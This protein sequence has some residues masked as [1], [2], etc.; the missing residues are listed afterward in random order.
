MPQNYY[1]PSW[2]HLKDIIPS[3]D[4]EGM[5]ESVLE[6]H[7]GPEQWRRLSSSGFPFRLLF[8]ARGR[9]QG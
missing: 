1:V 8:R 7:I 3:L 9:H 5:Q 4:V 2:S 6:I